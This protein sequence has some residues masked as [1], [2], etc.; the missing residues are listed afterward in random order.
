M[1]IM[2][3]FFRGKRKKI[4]SKHLIA[5][6]VDVG[7]NSPWGETGS[8]SFKSRVETL[9]RDKSDLVTRGTSCVS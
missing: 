3:S 6:R 7:A 1:C 5:R 4:N 8:F 9:R 2:L